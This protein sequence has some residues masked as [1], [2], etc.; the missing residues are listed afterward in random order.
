MLWGEPYDPGAQGIERALRWCREA[1]HVL[2][3][4]IHWPGGYPQF[5]GWPRYS[6][7]AHQQAYID[8]IER[9]HDGGLRL[10]CCSAVNNEVFADLFP[11]PGGARDDRS[12]I[13]RQIAGM[14]AMVAT[15]D[16][17]AGGPGQGWLEI[18]L[19]AGDARRISEEGRLAVVLGVEVDSLGNWRTPDDL[20]SDPAAA[21]AEVRSELE[22]LHASGVRLITPIHLTDNA[23][24]GAA[25]YRRMFD[26]LNRQVSGRHYVV[27]AAASSGIE[28]RLPDDLGRGDIDEFLRRLLYFFGSESDPSHAIPGGQAN[29]KGLTAHGRFL[30]SELMRLGMVIDIDHMSQKAAAE[31]VDLARN[32]RYPLVATH[33]AFRELALRS[34]ETDDVHKRAAEGLQTAAVVEAIGELGGMV[35]P[36]L[37]QGDIAAHGDRVPND[38]AGSSKSWAQA[39][40]YALEKMGGRGVALG[41][42]VNGLAGMPGPRFGTHAAATLVG[43]DRRRSQRRAQID[44]QTRGVRYEGPLEDT[45]A[46]RWD[47]PRDDGYTEA[48]AQAFEAVALARSGRDIL[49]ADLFEQHEPDSGVIAWIRHVAAGLRAER[50]EDLPVALGCEDDLYDDPEEVQ[51]GAFHAGSGVDPSSLPE[52]VIRDVCRLLAPVLAKADELEGPKARPEKPLRRCVA[53]RRDFDLNLDGL[54]HYGLLPDFLRDLHNVGLTAADLAPLLD[55]AAQFADVWRRCEEA[56]PGVAGT[57]A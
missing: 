37:N 32:A 56:A 34:T 2:P 24:G 28:Y 6:T 38:C 29:A 40:L 9:A 46:Y 43:D 30:I 36:I 39:Y 41:S 7:I 35:A 31:T 13:D 19:S 23:L 33:A 8:W 55:S 49:E 10:V 42:D 18:A 50:L 44:A 5:D 20:P 1:G 12:S 47:G 25:V 57:P 51:A 48:E 53:G 45:R 52:G 3:E 4:A 21:R 22:R 14:K 27:E 54:A 17:R 11:E 15:V 26:A 16:A